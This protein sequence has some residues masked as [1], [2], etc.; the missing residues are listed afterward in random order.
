MLIS[1]ALLG[2]GVG[3]AFAALGNLIVQAVPP[4]QTGAAGG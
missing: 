3:L 1:T 2:V 4:E